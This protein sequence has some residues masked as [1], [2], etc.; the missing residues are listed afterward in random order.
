MG[1][2]EV[3][4]KESLTVRPDLEF[5]QPGLGEKMDIR[6]LAQINERLEQITGQL[7]H[8]PEDSPERPLVEKEK[9]V[10]LQ[11]LRS[12]F[13][14]GYKTRGFDGPS[15]KAR[16]NVSRAI[17]SAYHKIEDDFPPL[18]AYLRGTIKIGTDCSYN[19]PTPT[20]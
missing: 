14:P 3:E 1:S 13:G 18:V 5:A 4:E 2:E 12:N 7:D 9:E 11:Y 10:L 17:T 16:K 20:P 15:E 19:P 6:A 8:M